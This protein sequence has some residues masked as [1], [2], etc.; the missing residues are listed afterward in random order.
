MKRHAEIVGGGI[1]GLGLANALAQ[2]GWDVQVHERGTQIREVGAGLYLRNNPL[3]VLERLGLFDAVAETGLRLE[4]ERRCDRWGRTRHEDRNVGEQRM[5]ALKRESL[6]RVLESAARRSGVT[7]RTGSTVV[8][9]GPEGTVRTEDGETFKADLVVGADGYHSVVRDS[10]GLTK[11]YRRL[12]SVATRYIIPGREFEPLPRTTMHW[13]GDRRVGV[14]PTTPDSTYIFLIAPEDDAP[15]V[16][17]PIDVASW[18]ASFPALAGLFQAIAATP[19]EPLQHNY[20]VV[21]AKRWSSG[22]AAILGDAAHGLPP[23]LGQGAGLA[24]SNAYA[25]ARVLDEEPGGVPAAL[26]RWERDYRHYA[27][28]TQ[29]WSCRLDSLTWKWPKPLLF[30]REPVLRAI[31]TA[32]W[33]EREMHI[34]DSFPVAG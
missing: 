6:I 30:A 14:T 15:G 20:M 19:S 1:G 31:Q 7:I 17:Y 13:S 2:R 4:I 28:V 9:A 24:L 27:D 23:L 3:T 25:L 8:H 16:A 34:A 22:V 11:T 10:L 29:K 33:W 26:A 32:P 18:S 5:W 12:S 21:E